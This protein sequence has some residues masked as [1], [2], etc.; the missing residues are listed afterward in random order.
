MECIRMRT[1]IPD[2][3]PATLT[4]GGA[5][6]PSCPTVGIGGGVGDGHAM[7]HPTELVLSGTQRSPPQDSGAA[8]AGE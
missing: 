3:R 1:W 7:S 4:A 8:C 2:F 5:R 6:A